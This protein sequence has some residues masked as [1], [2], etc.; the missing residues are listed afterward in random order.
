MLTIKKLEEFR[1]YLKS[2][3]FIKDFSMRTS[4]GQ[5]E[6]LDMIELLFEVCEL[7]DEVLTKHFYRNLNVKFKAEDF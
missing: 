4:D 7:A 5:A 2:G 1:D 6:M 3:D